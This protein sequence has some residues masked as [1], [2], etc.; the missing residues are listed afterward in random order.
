MSHNTVQPS[1]PKRRWFPR[2]RFMTWLFD[3]VFFGG[4]AYII[5]SGAMSHKATDCNGLSQHDCQAATD[6]GSTIG[7]ALLV[8]FWFAAIIVVGLIWLMTRP[9]RHCPACGHNA[10]KGQFLCKRCGHDFRTQRQ[11]GPLP[12]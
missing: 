8:V 4:L 11:P 9:R 7:I 2:L 3:L 6:V 1:K 5:A 10:K 12:V